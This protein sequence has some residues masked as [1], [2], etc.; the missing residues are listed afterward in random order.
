MAMVNSV[1]LVGNLGQDLETRFTQSGTAVANFSLATNEPYMKGKE[2][3]KHTEWH[4]IVVFGKLAETCSQYLQKGSQVMISGRL[5]TR[6]WTDKDGV[7][8]RTTEVHAEKIQF[9]A[10]TRKKEEAV[11]EQEEIQAPPMVQEIEL[12]NSP[13]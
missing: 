13:F 5:R 12:E 6:S 10:K 8:R 3:Q 7:A 4:R 9:L 2:K 1:T 11:V